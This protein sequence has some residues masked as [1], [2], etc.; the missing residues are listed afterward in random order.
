[1]LERGAVSSLPEV[2]GV[3]FLFNKKKK[4]V[5]VG[6][7]DSLKHRLT[8]HKRNFEH[9][10]KIKEEIKKKGILA[11]PVKYDVKPFSF[12]RYSIIRNE[13]ERDET[14]IS[15]IVSLR[16]RY[17]WRTIRSPFTTLLVRSD[18]FTT[19]IPYITK[20]LRESKSSDYLRW[21][22]SFKKVRNL[23]REFEERKPE[24]SWI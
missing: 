18:P 3:Y 12:F 7:A 1:M 23:V 11:C 16:P 14:E 20:E 17:N 22:I 5:Y 13:E 19:G 21:I 24:E 15:L 6:K 8:A 4:L 9:F 2:Q 10:L